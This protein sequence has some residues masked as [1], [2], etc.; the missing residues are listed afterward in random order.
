MNDAFLNEHSKTNPK[1]HDIFFI[2]KHF[3]LQNNP[4]LYRS[5]LHHK[6]SCCFS[7][8]GK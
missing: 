6:S 7:Y 4:P 2:G 3:K 5:H 1:A 8:T